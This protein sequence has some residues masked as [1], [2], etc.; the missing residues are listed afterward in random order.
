[1]ALVL[2]ELLAGLAVLTTLQ[3]RHAVAA[4]KVE[5]YSTFPVLLLAAGATLA[6]PAAVSLA[7][8]P[9][10][11]RALA[12]AAVVLLV[13]AAAAVRALWDTSLPHVTPRQERESPTPSTTIVCPATP[14][15]RI[16]AMRMRAKYEPFLRGEGD[17]DG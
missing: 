14:R 11:T 4:Q 13:G 7:L 2:G 16:H 6:L 3:E 8:T 1:M 9:M 10:R 12:I 5:S 15:R 17:S